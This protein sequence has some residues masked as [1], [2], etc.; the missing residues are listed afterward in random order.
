MIVAHVLRSA[1]SWITFPMVCVS[2]VT[3]KGYNRWP[4]VAAIEENDARDGGWNCD[5]CGKS[6]TTG[7]DNAIQGHV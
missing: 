3:N 1:Q 7:E 5:A 4:R 2:C 6:L